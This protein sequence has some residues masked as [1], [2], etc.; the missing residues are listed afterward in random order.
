MG[1]IVN[2]INKI[3]EINTYNSLETK[4]KE[5]EYYWNNILVYGNKLP[6]IQKLE[7]GTLYSDN[8]SYT[9]LKNKRIV[10]KFIIYTGIAL[11]GVSSFLSMY[12][13]IT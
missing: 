1:R 5:Q 13:S 4:I 2:L 3:N 11:L 6:F 7:E 9:K 8:N 10:N 12:Q